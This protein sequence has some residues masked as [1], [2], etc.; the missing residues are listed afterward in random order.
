MALVIVKK[1]QSNGKAVED[2]LPWLQIV[3]DTKSK[4]TC[5]RLELVSIVVSLHELK[6]KLR[7]K[8]LLLEFLDEILG[9]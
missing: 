2:W 9:T 1:A 3:G 4:L 7:W 5:H 8:R 6:E